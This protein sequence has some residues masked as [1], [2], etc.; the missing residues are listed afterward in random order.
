MTI[1]VI[2]LKVAAFESPT[3][4]WKCYRYHTLRDWL[5]S[6]FIRTHSLLRENYH[7]ILERAIANVCPIL[8]RWLINRLLHEISIRRNLKLLVDSVKN[9]KL[10][11]H[12]ITKRKTEIELEENAMGNRERCN[13]TPFSSLFESTITMQHYNANYLN[14]V[15]M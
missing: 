13:S 12:I 10:E 9:I 3:N 1:V 7:L 2:S 4:K 5:G 6:N 14:C 15:K 8:V 11:R